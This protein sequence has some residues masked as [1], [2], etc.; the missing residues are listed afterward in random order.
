MVRSILNTAFSLSLSLSPNSNSFFL[1]DLFFMKTC[2][3]RSAK[4]RSVDEGLFCIDEPDSRYGL[5][6]C[7]DCS[8]CLPSPDLASQQSKIRF[9]P[10]ETFRFMNGYETILNCSANCQTRNII[11]AMVCPCN[12]AE[13]IGETS[14]RLNDRLWCKF[15]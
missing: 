12:N 11:Y 14:Q 4:P 6:P 9:G 2:S 1:V 13:Y 3:F 7:N 8:L 5:L 10:Q 15:L